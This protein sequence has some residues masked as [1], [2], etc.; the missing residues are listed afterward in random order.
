MDN[1]PKHYQRAIPAPNISVHVKV[2]GGGGEVGEERGE[3]RVRGG[4]VERGR[5]RGKERQ[6]DWQREKDRV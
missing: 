4:G 1:K 6:T 2:E 3:R 5:G